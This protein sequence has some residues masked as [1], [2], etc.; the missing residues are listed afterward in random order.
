[1]ASVG[2]RFGR[3]RNCASS[4]RALHKAAVFLPRDPQSRQLASEGRQSGRRQEPRRGP[5]SKETP[6]ARRPPQGMIFTPRFVHVLPAQ[7]MEFV[8][9]VPYKLFCY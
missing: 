8:R 2:P 1:M 4:N 3:G 6:L 5:I 7:S 9:S